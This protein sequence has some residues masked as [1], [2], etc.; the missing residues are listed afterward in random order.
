MKAAIYCRVRSAGQEENYSLDTQE[1]GCRIRAAEHRIGGWLA[2][3]ATFILVRNSL[4]AP[5]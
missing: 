5:R 1:Q 2:S 4:S 3:S